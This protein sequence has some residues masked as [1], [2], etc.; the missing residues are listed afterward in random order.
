MSVAESV[1]T[2]YRVT[3][4]G[5]IKTT[6]TI[7]NVPVWLVAQGDGLVRQ[8][9]GNVADPVIDSEVAAV[10]RHIPGWRVGEWPA[11]F[12][13]ETE[14]I[15]LPPGAKLPGEDQGPQDVEE[16]VKKAMLSE[17]RFIGRTP[18]ERRALREERER[19]AQQQAV[20][21]EDREAAAARIETQGREPVILGQDI[22]DNLVAKLSEMMAEIT[23]L[24]TQLGTAE[25]TIAS[26]EVENA[27]F[28]ARIDAAGRQPVR[29]ASPGPGEGP[30]G[31][32]RSAPTAED[33]GRGPNRNPKR[34]RGKAAP[35]PDDEGTGVVG[36][37]LAGMQRA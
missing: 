35:N 21:A 24:H 26:L 29:P 28:R 16:I 14:V 12:A 27:A 34:S 25:A 18:Q 19:L 3:R 1:N 33:M 20:G 15:K 8:M 22:D 17:M 31:I 30:D 7:G 6:L 5:E 9:R 36:D 23:V 13:P 2:K 32:V 37:A 11:D 10:L 4:E